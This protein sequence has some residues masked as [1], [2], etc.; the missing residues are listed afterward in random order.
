MVARQRRRGEA[1]GPEHP[2]LGDSLSNLG[3]LYRYSSDL[4]RAEALGRQALAQREAGLGPDH[5]DTAASLNNLAAALQDRGDHAVALPLLANLLVAEGRAGEALPMLERALKIDEKA[6]IR[7]RS[8]AKAWFALA[9]ALRRAPPPNRDE[10][11]AVQLAT[12]AADA[13][14]AAGDAEKLA[15]VEAWLRGP[16]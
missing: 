1:L 8:L 9:R 12:R 4:D 7:P 11:R 14:R 10:P 2:L 13:F 15:A 16:E 5:P 3:E 6:G